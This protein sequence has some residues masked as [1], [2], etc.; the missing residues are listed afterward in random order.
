MQAPGGA[1]WTL[2]G[3]LYSRVGKHTPDEATIRRFT[4]DCDPF[5]ALMIALCAAQYDRCIRPQHVDPSLRS[6]RNDTMMAI[7]LPY[8]DE[9]VT[10]DPKQSASYKEVVSIAGLNTSMKSYEDFRKGLLVDAH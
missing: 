7:C 9:F 10:A 3:R 6:G 1:F 8:C 2:A 5:R 4:N